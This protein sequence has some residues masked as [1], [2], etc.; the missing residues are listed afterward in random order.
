MKKI[1]LGIG[2]LL[3][4]VSGYGQ[5]NMIDNVFEKY[6]GAKGFVTVSISGDML[7]MMTKAEMER[8][9][10]VIQSKLS[11]IRILAM[12]ENCEKQS[13][14]NFKSEIFDKLDK[15]VYKEMVS[16]KKTG[17]DVLIMIKEKGGHISEM[18]V[19]VGGSK[20]N[21]LVHITGDI[22]LREMNDMM[23]RFPMRGLDHMD[24]K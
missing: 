4:T 23:G 18:L 16:V 3:I 19:L 20:T 5:K 12:D 15:A 10:T 1:F 8:R 24:W 21:A 22:L 6:S 11:A 7:N 9:D 2:I 14:I 13:N 17:E